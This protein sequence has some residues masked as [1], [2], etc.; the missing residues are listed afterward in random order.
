M[1]YCL[2][3]SN[4][5]LLFITAYMNFFYNKVIYKKAVTDSNQYTI[6][7]TQFYLVDLHYNKVSKPLGNTISLQTHPYDICMQEFWPFSE[8]DLF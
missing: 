2:L 4:F 5:N 7:S 3:V 1:S 8:N 6:G